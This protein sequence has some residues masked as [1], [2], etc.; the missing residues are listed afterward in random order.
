MTCQQTC[1]CDPHDLNGEQALNSSLVLKMSNKENFKDFE[2]M[3]QKKNF[4]PSK[5][6]IS[7]VNNKLF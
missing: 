6:V 7:R 5:L 1:A 3:T 4:S 2:A